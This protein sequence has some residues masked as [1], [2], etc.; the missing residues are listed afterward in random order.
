MDE[1]WEKRAADMRS[2]ML[3]LHRREM[4]NL[5]AQIPSPVSSPLKKPWTALRNV[6]SV[7]RSRLV[8]FHDG[9][10]APGGTLGL[11]FDGAAAVSVEAPDEDGGLPLPAVSGGGAAEAPVVGS[12]T[13]SAAELLCDGFEALR[14]LSEDLRHDLEAEA[15]AQ[16]TR[17]LAAMASEQ[18]A[19]LQALEELAEQ[20]RKL[21]EEREAE[22]HR[23]LADAASVL[24][25]QVEAATQLLAKCQTTTP[26]AV[27]PA[28]PASALSYLAMSYHRASTATPASTLAS[29][30]ATPAS[31]SASTPASSH[32]ATSIAEL[33]PSPQPTATA[34][35]PSTADAAESASRTPDEMPSWLQS[36]QTILEG[37]EA[38]DGSTPS[39][40]TPQRVSPLIHP[41]A[42]PSPQPTP[43]MVSPPAVFSW[44][45][46]TMDAPGPEDPLP[47][48]TRG[49][50]VRG[51]VSLSRRVLMVLMLVAVGLLL[52][53]SEPLAPLGT[54]GLV[55]HVGDVRSRPPWC[56]AAEPSLHAV[57]LSTKDATGVDGFETGRALP[58]P[59]RK[60][61]K[62]SVAASW[63]RLGRF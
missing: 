26:T 17:L 50:S 48:A 16:R 2:R 3:K 42:T 21:T 56:A 45:A 27:L 58:T 7:G 52:S 33:T 47:L 5:H 22:L 14:A 44:R 29:T 1:S 40:G 46:A 13:G 37:G 55:V 35:P 53:R 59:P 41:A 9:P 54:G 32:A 51:L 8:P 39:T 31:L 36:A 18:R 43:K 25:S 62:R 6:H 34:T 4:E 24:M 60:P 30:I 61:R 20:Q 10:R 57:V 11:V 49:R 15:E 19:H 12:T 28:T 23:S 63:F 38:A